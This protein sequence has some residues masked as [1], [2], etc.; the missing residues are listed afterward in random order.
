M[1]ILNPRSEMPPIKFCP[2]CGK[3]AEVRKPSLLSWC[4][5]CGWT[6]AINY[7]SRHPARESRKKA[8][9]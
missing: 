3:Q 6:W 4:P 8:G 9:K 2:Y 7:T 5:S 1:S